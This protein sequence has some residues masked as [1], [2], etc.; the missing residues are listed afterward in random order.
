MNPHMTVHGTATIGSKGQIVIP[1][2]A[3]ESLGLATGDKVLV[4]SGKKGCLVICPMDNIAGFLDAQ[5]KQLDKLQTLIN[6]E[7]DETQ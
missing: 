4:I 6:D 7:K 2:D 5:Q 1:S 3:R